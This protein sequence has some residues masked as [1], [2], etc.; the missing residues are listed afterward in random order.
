MGILTMLAHFHLINKGKH[1]FNLAINPTGI[2]E[3][4]SAAELN[5]EQVKFV[6]ETAI[7]VNERSKYTTSG[8]LIG[9]TILTCSLEAEISAA[10]EATAFS[11]DYYFLSQLYDEEWK[12]TPTA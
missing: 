3:L 4:A 8:W 10:R 9:C 12:P 11:H 1:P 7:M 5:E 2:K 6:K